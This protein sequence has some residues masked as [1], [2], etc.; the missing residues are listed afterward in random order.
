VLTIQQ[1]TDQWRKASVKKN[2]ALIMVS[3]YEFLAYAYEGKPAA[4][5]TQNVDESYHRV[6]AHQHDEGSG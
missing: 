2:R 3:G 4:F 1:E 6:S 5:K